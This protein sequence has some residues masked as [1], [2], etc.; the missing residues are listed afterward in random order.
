MKAHS[1]QWK[2]LQCVANNEQKDNIPT[3]RCGHSLTFFGST[4][5][6]LFGGMN[7]DGVVI[8]DTHVLT[9]SNQVNTWHKV[10]RQEIVP[11]GRW[12][13]TATKI[14]VSQMIIYGGLVGDESECCN[15]VWLFNTATNTWKCQDTSPTLFRSS[16]ATC[17]IHK[18][19][20]V[21]G[22]MGGRSSKSKLYL[23]DLSVLSTKTWKW[24]TVSDKE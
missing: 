12:K 15:E 23:S 22:G 6:V 21:F 24:Q 2:K 9:L 11:K 18:D 17:L 3:G 5:I 19:A 20:Y 8:N 4:S 7:S 10:K 14:S 16:H 13:H 1:L